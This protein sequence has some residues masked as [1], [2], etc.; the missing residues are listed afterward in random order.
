M[1]QPLSTEARNHAPACADTSR[2]PRAARTAGGLTKMLATTRPP[3]SRAMSARATDGLRGDC[4][5][6]APASRCA[7]RPS[8]RRNSAIVL[9]YLHD[10]GIKSHESLSSGNRPAFTSV[11]YCRTA[12]SMLVLPSMKLRTNRNGSP[13]VTPSMSCSTEH[14]AAATGA[15]A[16]ADGR[17]RQRAASDRV[18]RRPGPSRAPEAPAPAAASSSA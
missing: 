4:P 6:S 17:Y 1:S 9:D 10:I 14:L 16:D 2:N 13:R 11:T 8:A 7:S 15:G 3:R 5:S 18:Q 12:S